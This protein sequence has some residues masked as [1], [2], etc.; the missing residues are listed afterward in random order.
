MTPHREAIVRCSK[1]STSF[2]ILTLGAVMLAGCKAQ[3]RIR[4]VKMGDV[5]RFREILATTSSA[6]LPTVRCSIKRSFSS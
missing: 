4:P 5:D 1:L 3:P 2:M 6:A